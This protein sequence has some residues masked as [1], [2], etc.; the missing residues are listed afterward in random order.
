M[1]RHRLAAGRGGGLAG[2]SGKGDGKP[3]RPASLVTVRHLT[4]DDLRSSVARLLNDVVCGGRS[5]QRRR[6][7]LRHG[8]KG[9]GKAGKAVYTKKNSTSPHSVDKQ[10]CSAPARCHVP[11]PGGNPSCSSSQEEAFSFRRRVTGR[12]TKRC[13]A[14]LRGRRQR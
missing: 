2:L 10:R 12:G 6:P 5:C 14:S 11:D 1:Q 13:H 4:T 7:S 3:A 9:D 8:G